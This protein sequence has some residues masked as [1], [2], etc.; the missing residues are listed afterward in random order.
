MASEGVGSASEGVGSASEG[1]ER[2]YAEA[3][4]RLTRHGQ[5]HVLGFWA[6]L[7]TA[8]RLRLLADLD[9]VDLEALTQAWPAAGPH[10]GLG[11][12]VEPLREAVPLP[13][14]GEAQAR[15]AGEQA[16]RDGRVAA[17]LVAGGQGTRLGYDGPKGAFALGPVSGRSLFAMHA[18]RLVA[19]GRRFGRVPFLYVMASPEN[20]A[21]TRAFF[22]AHECFGLP[23]DRVQIFPQ[24][25]LPAVD[26]DGRLLLAAPDRLVLAPNGN[27]GLFAAME[28]HGVFAQMREHGVDA[29]SYFHVDNAL[30]ASCDARF[31]GHH[32]L[33]ESEFSCKSVRRSEPLEAVGCFARRADRLCIVEYTELP[34]RLASARDAAGE[35]LFGHGNP[36]LFVWSRGFAERQAARRDLP[37]HRAHKR[38]AH[39]DTSG[40]LISPPTPNAFKLE[41]FALDTLP[42][43][44]RAIVVACTRDEEF[45]P[46]KQA[47]GV[48]SPESA[49]AL[50]GALHRGWIERAGGVVAPGARVEISPL[51]ALDA[52]EL[53]SRL[54]RAFLAQTDTY[55]HE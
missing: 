3:C 36:G 49:R 45:A 50:L 35:L 14:P 41:T 44:D 9:L 19:L 27:G 32:L 51:Y 23:P 16:L 5:A 52:A 21:V 40:R 55:L 7:T 28:Q 17:L 37:V 18:E 22:L 47:S 11:G 31:V 10:P 2:R 13:D 33:A 34:A 30:A 43:A 24:G 20:V 25:V 15:A 46:V 48:D 6:A 54:P 4:Q 8:G 53:A 42:A 1:L 38:I 39:L 26:A 12:G 29:I